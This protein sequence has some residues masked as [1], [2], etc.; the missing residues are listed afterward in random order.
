VLPEIEA[1]QPD[2]LAVTGDHATPSILAAHGW[3]PVPVLLHGP[4]AGRDAVDTFT[5]RACAG[6]SLG[7]MPAFHL[8]P[9]LMANALR[10][11]KFGA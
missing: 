4:Y 7:T 6:G 11:T 9:L 10:L 3:Q 5:E 1:L 2:V 8:M